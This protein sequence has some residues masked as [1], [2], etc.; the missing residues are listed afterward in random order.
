MLHLYG[1]YFGTPLISLIKNISLILFYQPFHHDHVDEIGIDI[2]LESSDK[3]SMK[4]GELRE[5]RKLRKEM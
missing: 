2:V 1:T 4:N 3:I 5:L